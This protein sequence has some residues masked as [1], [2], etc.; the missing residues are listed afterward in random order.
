MIRS[1]ED[2]LAGAGGVAIY[3]RRWEPEAAPRGVVLV[4]HGYAEHIGR[5]VGFAEHLASRRLAVAGIDH[6]GHGRSGGKRVATAWLRLF[7]LVNI[8]LHLIFWER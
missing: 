8:C 3:S 1:T 2:T 4:V 7:G 6:R 5:Y